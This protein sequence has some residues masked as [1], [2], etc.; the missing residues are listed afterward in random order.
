[1]G[2]LHK[3]TSLKLYIKT[4]FINLVELQ[5]EISFYFMYFTIIY[6]VKYST[7]WFTLQNRWMIKKLLCTYLYK[8]IQKYAKSNLIFK[9]FIL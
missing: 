8:P 5:T 1:M 9:Y 2:I 7:T 3:L 6:I 4:K